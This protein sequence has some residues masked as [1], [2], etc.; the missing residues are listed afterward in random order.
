MAITAALPLSAKMSGSAL[1]TQQTQGLQ[2]VQV[3]LLHS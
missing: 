1:L 3:G 2:A